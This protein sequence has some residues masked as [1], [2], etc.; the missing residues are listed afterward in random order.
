M[1]IAKIVS[2]AIIGVRAF[3]ITIEI[4]VSK[5]IG[6]QV[7]G[8][9]D[10]SIKESLSR[11]GVAL[12]HCGYKMPRTK[13]LIHLSPASIRKSGS[14]FDVPIALGIL[15]ATGQIT[16][17]MDI[18]R[19]NI[20]GELGLDGAIKAIPGTL[21]R[22]ELSVKEK[23]NGFILPAMNA[24]EAVLIPNS[25]ILPVTHLHN[26]I[27]FIEGKISIEPAIK[28]SLITSSNN[29]DNDFKNV[30][31]QEPVKRALEI[32]AAGGHH[33]LISG[34]PGTGKSMLAKCLPSILPAMNEREII[35]TTKI[36]GLITHLPIRHLA[37]ARP[38][39]EVHH[40]VSIAGLI[41]GGISASPGEITHAHN[42]V[43]FMDEFTECKTT[44]LE[45]L[46]QPLEEKKVHLARAGI[47]IE[48]PAA[49]MLVAAINPCL[50]G[51]LDHPI[52]KCTCSKRALFWHKRKLS[53][54]IMDRFDL[55][56]QTEVT[57]I[58]DIL[59]PSTTNESSAVIAERVNRARII[60]R[61]R[62]GQHS[63]IRCNAELTHEL[64]QRFCVMDEHAAKFLSRSWNNIQLSMRG[65]DKVLKVAR[66]IADLAGTANIELQHIAEALHYR[67]N[68]YSLE[69]TA[70]QRNPG[71]V[72]SLKN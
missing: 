62:L 1:M 55:F 39:R 44:V 41:G 37:T 49:F 24:A 19:Y 10:E 17:A 69:A 3:P 61:E 53:G 9:V 43:L 64:I 60:Q 50:C 29:D 40:S 18:A 11:I 35:E 66:T 32:A 25:N 58:T 42:G 15:L 4:S 34:F 72:F 14:A 31:G 65:M 56:A 2:S 57:G 46:R 52:K 12:E 30:V 33:T 36:N 22:S 63:S 7:T 6:Y 21:I 8:M 45:S 47:K 59:Q 16:C 23:Y 51:N 38:F 71:K 13:L 20:A 54:P 27:E 26:V 70:K 5:G 28:P 68:N 67:E 48:Y